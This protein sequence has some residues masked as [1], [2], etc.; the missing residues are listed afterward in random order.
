MQPPQLPD[1]EQVCAVTSI[2]FAAVV[3]M[4]VE[5]ADLPD[6]TRFKGPSRGG[7]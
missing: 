2:A 1:E 6:L 5:A 4:L 7:F 3:V